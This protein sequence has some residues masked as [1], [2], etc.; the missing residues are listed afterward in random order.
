MKTENIENKDELV[1]NYEALSGYSLI[2]C[3]KAAKKEDPTIS[4][5]SLSQIYQAHVAA[6]AA[7][8][9]VDDILSLPAKKFTKV[10]LEAQ[11]FLLGSAN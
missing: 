10:T 7:G 9:K 6:A 5:P 11:N 3:E 8:V 1:F 4:V 2:Q